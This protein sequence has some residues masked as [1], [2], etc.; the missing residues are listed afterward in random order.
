MLSAV[1][2]LY[3][4]EQLLLLLLGQVVANVFD[5][6]HIEV[7][8]S[9]RF[10]RVD[11]VPIV[12]HVLIMHELERFLLNNAELRVLVAI[13]PLA[14]WLLRYRVLVLRDVHA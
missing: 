9:L 6:G 3:L 14:D 11:L 4:L 7:P 13:W 12:V 10:S 2:L 5:V 1:D 8:S